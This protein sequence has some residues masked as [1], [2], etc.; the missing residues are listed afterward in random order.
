MRIE[1]EMHGEYNLKTIVN[2]QKTLHAFYE[3]TKSIRLFLL[4]DYTIL[5]FNKKAV[6]YF[7]ALFGKRLQAG[8]DINR[9]LKKSNMKNEFIFHFEKALKAGS[10]TSEYVIG[11]DSEKTW[12][13]IDY[14]TVVFGTKTIGISV[15]MRDITHHKM[16]ESLLTHQKN[17]LDDI[18]HSQSHLFRSPVANILGLLENMDRSELS[19][20]N[21]EL[22]ECTE[23]SA[24][25]L[26]KLI[27]TIVFSAHGA[28]EKSNDATS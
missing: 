4:P 20:N 1:T 22:I 11:T 15:S 2:M 7:P 18:I 26:D 6:E 8:V 28:K 9:L 19:E 16:K 17:V 25:E 14:H 5:F 13:K 24:R 3:S 27:K 10:S 21:R 23:I 12:Y